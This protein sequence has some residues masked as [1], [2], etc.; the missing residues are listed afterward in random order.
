[1]EF[2]AIPLALLAGLLSLLSPCV[3]P[4]IPA[5]TASAMRA[6]RTGVWFLAAGLA[7]TFALGGSLLTYLL[8]SAS[9][10]PEI[11]R[12]FA[13]YFMLAMGLVL[14][15]DWLNQQFSMLLSRLT[16]HLP[17]GGQVTE[18]TDHPAFQ[19]VV[20]GSLGL[21]WLPCV[22]PTLGAAIALASTGQSMLM[23][24]SVMLAFGLGTAL[25]LVAVGYAAGVKLSKLRTSGKFGRKLL[26][27]ALLLIALMIF[28]GFDKVLELWA[29]EFLPDWV[30]GI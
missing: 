28:S 13:A 25:P 21:V 14:S 20:G 18:N 15:V 26:G 4:M 10:G 24:F 19:F 6:S 3:L 30:S 27:Y 12:T 8:L 23:S 29:I 7:L 17:S 22:G 2:T 16:S 9:L 11:M 1:M 5:V